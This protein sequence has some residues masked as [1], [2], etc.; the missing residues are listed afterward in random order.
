M[1]LEIGGKE[2]IKKKYYFVWFARDMERK[3]FVF[4]LFNF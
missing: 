4:F 2:K 1:C 3:I